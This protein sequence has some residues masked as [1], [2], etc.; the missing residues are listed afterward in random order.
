MY[1]KSKFIFFVFNFISH[2]FF[3]SQNNDKKMYRFVPGVIQS[4]LRYPYIA[5]K[6]AT[7]FDPPLDLICLN[8]VD[9]VQ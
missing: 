7:Q 3:L 8:E 4:D 9:K 6:I 2:C 5:D 1:L